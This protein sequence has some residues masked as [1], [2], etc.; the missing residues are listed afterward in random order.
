MKKLNKDITKEIIQLFPDFDS[1]LESKENLKAIGYNSIAV[2]SFDHWLSYDEY[3]AKEKL[4]FNQEKLDLENRAKIISSFFPRVYLYEYNENK[5]EDL[6][7][8]PKNKRE[9]YNYILDSLIKQQILNFIVDE[10]EMLISTTPDLTDMYYF[11]NKNLISKIYKK[12]KEHNL[13]CFICK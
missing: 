11:K 9:C 4:F 13:K 12:V 6:L 2:G 5:D 7:F 8:E 1:L 10:P 3:N